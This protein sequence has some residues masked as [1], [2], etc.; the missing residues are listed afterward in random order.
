MKGLYPVDLHSHTI[1]SDGND[2][3]AELMDNALARGVKVLALTDHDVLPQ[4][5][6]KTQDGQEVEPVSYALS[7]GLVFIPGVEYSCQTEIEDCHIVTLFCDWDDPR[8][9][10]LE[11]DISKSKVESYLALLDRLK[12]RGMEVDLEELLQMGT[13]IP[14]ESLQKKRIFDYMAFKG[15]TKT[16]S[17]AK[18]M[19]RQDPTLNVPRRKPDALE[20]IKTAKEVGGV[21]ILAH[22]YLMDPQ[23]KRQGQDLTRAEFIELMIEAGLDGIEKIYPYDKTTT[24]DPRPKEIIWQEVEELY[25]GRLFIS[26]GSDYHNDAKKGTANPRMLGEAGLTLEDFKTTPVYERLSPEQKALLG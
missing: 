13:P 1:H 19:V 7:K 21:V 5:M 15:Y 2:T 4:K 20:L 11:E 3:M 24:L 26:G 10:A 6:M 23:L 25:K 22:P 12:D 17:E 8:M 18:L 9:K 14:V 16:W